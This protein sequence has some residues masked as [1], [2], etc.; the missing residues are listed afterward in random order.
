MKKALELLPGALLLLLVT[1]SATHAQEPESY[2]QESES[3]GQDS[4][5]E[6]APRSQ[7]FDLP[8]YNGYRLDWCLVWSDHCGR[9]AAH[10]FCLS[11]G[12]SDVS[13]F[14]KDPGVAQTRLI[15]TDQT[16][17]GTSGIRCDSFVY[18]ICQ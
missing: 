4:A 17:P 8:M 11:Q 18:I 16:C 3:H 14:A 9:E 1:A 12:Y 13:D 5:Q 7:R 15:G 6:L 10:A 2:A